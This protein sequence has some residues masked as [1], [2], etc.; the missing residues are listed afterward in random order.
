MSYELVLYQYGLSMLRE[1]SDSLAEFTKSNTNDSKSFIYYLKPES[2][3]KFFD[4][5]DCEIDKKAKKDSFYNIYKSIYT[6]YVQYKQNKALKDLNSGI[7]LK[8]FESDNVYKN[9][10]I[11]G[12]SMDT[13]TFE[14]ACSLARFYS[15]DIWRVYMAFTEFLLTD[16]E[17]EEFSSLQELENR[18]NPLAET[19]RSRKKEFLEYMNLKIMPVLDGKSLDKLIV[20]YNLLGKLI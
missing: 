1:L 11:I 16:N 17:D 9:D 6:K 13:E 5:I 2:L 12:L 7:D 4:C 14:L 3:L 20:F 8:R 15:F 19:L 18:L 10:T